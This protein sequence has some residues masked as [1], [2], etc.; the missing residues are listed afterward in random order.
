MKI[1]QVKTEKLIPYAR[2]PKKHDDAQVA[3][4]AGSI[5]EFGFNNPVLIDK[6]NCIIA[7]HGRVLAAQKLEL[8]E[9]PCLR[10]SHLSENQKRAYILADNRLAELGGGWDEEM[11][12]LELEDIDFADFSNFELGDLGNIGDIDNMKDNKGAPLNL[13]ENGNPQ[14]DVEKVFCPKCGFAYEVK[15]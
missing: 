10:L 15:K 4:I 2:N 13:E 7:G 9:V 1:E 6:D 5:K 12:K 8:K 3:S 11:L 14:P